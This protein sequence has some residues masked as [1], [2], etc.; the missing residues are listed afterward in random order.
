VNSRFWQLFQQTTGYVHHYYSVV[1]ESL[2]VY[3]KC[4]TRYV[5]LLFHMSC[6]LISKKYCSM[7]QY[8]LSVDGPVTRW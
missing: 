6:T 3:Q 1:L 7:W 8:C 2:S 5:N 4:F